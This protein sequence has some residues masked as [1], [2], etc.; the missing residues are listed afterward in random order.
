M[1]AAFDVGADDGFHG[2]MFA[3][4]NPKV[5]VFAFEPIRGSKSKIIKNLRKI[6]K[7]FKLKIKNYKII[8][9]AI[10]DFNGTH[11]FYETDYGVASSLLKPE[12]KLNKF[13]EDTTDHLFKTVVKGTKTKKRYKVKVLTLEKF[14]KTNSIK[15]INYLHVDAQGHDLRVIK[16]LKG[17]KKNLIEGVAEVPSDNKFK[18]YKKEQSYKD[19]KKKFKIWK[20]KITTVE[21]IQKNFPYYNVYFKNENIETN[22]QNKINFEYPPKRIQRMFKR[23]F[24]DKISWKDYIYYFFWKFKTNII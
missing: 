15:I 20:F 22:K 18:F 12:K 24:F 19:L 7:F 6:E 4:M 1:N 14:C 8:N 2:I 11:I 9:T 3:F 5:K 21:E 23:I 13:W 16:G 17:F 10:S